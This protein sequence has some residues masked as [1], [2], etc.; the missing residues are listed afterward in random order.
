MQ[1]TANVSL[2]DSLGFR[3]DNAL[4]LWRQENLIDF[5]K[6]S[7]ENSPDAN[8]ILDDGDMIVVPKRNNLVYVFGQ[9]ADAGYQEIQEGKDAFYYINK[10]GGTTTIAKDLEETVLIK[11]KSRNWLYVND[12]K[13]KIESGDF[14]WVPK[15]QEK[16]FKYY[17]ELIAPVASIIGTI[18]TIAILIVQLNQ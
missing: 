2:E 17:M 6:I 5:T 15:R 13:A 8:Y 1:R 7:D 18:A 16:D 12:K 4:R 9:V 14:I 10:A 11:G 3:L